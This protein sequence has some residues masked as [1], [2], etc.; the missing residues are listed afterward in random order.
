M[1]V[2]SQDTHH[3]GIGR[4]ST[5]SRLLHLLVLDIGSRLDDL[6]LA[7]RCDTGLFQL[8]LNSLLI[9]D[10]D[11]IPDLTE[12]FVKVHNQ[13]GVVGPDHLSMVILLV[14]CYKKLPFLLQLVYRLL[15][16][17]PAL[18]EFPHIHTRTRSLRL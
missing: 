14:P 4:L 2:V 6:V 8:L 7:R 18:A 12:L 15:H 11:F 17:W 5:S 3:V 9:R 16:L 1:G 13:R 10:P